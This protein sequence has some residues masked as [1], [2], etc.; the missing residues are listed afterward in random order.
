VPTTNATDSERCGTRSEMHKRQILDQRDIETTA[1][2]TD[3]ARN[4]ASVHPRAEPF[5]SRSCIL[6]PGYGRILQLRREQRF[7][8]FDANASN[9]EF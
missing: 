3:E 6:D 5:K 9:G 1:I 7:E 4:G 2:R 8:G